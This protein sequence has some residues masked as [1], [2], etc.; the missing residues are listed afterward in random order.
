MPSSG[1]TASR[2]AAKGSARASGSISAPEEVRTYPDTG[3]D[4]A[5]GLKFF[6]GMT[7]RG[8]Y[9][10]DDGGKPTHHGFSAAHT[11]ADI[12]RVLQATEDTVK[13]IQA[14]R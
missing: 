5:L 12:D 14:G 7:E 1:G 3:Q 10:C 6:A 8:V 4:A 11:P 9:F 13:A 2:P